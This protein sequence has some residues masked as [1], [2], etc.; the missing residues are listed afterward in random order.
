LSCHSSTYSRDST[1]PP[2]PASNNGPALTAS[3]ANVP[4]H[5]TENDETSHVARLDITI[6]SQGATG[7]QGIQ[8]MTG[9]PHAP[10]SIETS[11]RT[12]TKLENHVRLCPD[13]ILAK[14]SINR[15]LMVI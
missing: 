2:A 15:N 9:S 8:G 13:D 12:A 3:A 5:A 6:T 11:C 10:F 7:A 1:T 4:M 14:R